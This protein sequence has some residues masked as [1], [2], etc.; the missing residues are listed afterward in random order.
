MKIMTM[1]EINAFWGRFK[2][3]LG[4]FLA[5]VFLGVVLRVAGLRLDRVPPRV[6][7]VRA[8]TFF[9]EL[10]VFCFEPVVEVVFFFVMTILS[11]NVPVHYNIQPGMAQT[12]W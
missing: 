8:V 5:A 4:F 12:L 6:V 9:L 2:L 10:V 7:L 11:S 1:P 3:K